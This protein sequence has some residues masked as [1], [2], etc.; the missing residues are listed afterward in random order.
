MPPL[1]PAPGVTRAVFNYLSNGV[2]T[3]NVIHFTA[4]PGPDAPDPANLASDLASWWKLNIAPLSS[5]NHILQ[6]VVCTD[7]SASGPPAV[8]HTTGLPA[9]GTQAGESLPNNAALVMSL[10]TAL[11]GRSF[12][13][14]L[15][16]GGIAESQASGNNVIASFRDNAVIEWSEIILFVTAPLSPDLQLVVLSY[17]SG[18]AVRGTPVATPVTSITA[19]TRIDTMRRR[20]R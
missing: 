14:R 10:R 20:M 9:A 15:Y 5:V 3:A 16:M 6:S 18:G 8:E 11:R 4:P 2:A 7:L 19:D 17:F 12:R 13:G 1:P